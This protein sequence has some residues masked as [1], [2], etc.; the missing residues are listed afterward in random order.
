MLKN[1]DMTG[2]TLS[3]LSKLD[4]LSLR[5]CRGLDLNDNMIEGLSLTSLTITPK[6]KL[7]VSLNSSITDIIKNQTNLTNLS[8]GCFQINKTKPC[9]FLLSLTHLATLSMSNVSTIGYKYI[10]E[11]TSLTE[12]SLFSYDQ[13][14]SD[15]T[16]DILMHL[17]N[18]KCLK[19]DQDNIIVMKLS[20]LKSLTDLNVHSYTSTHNQHLSNLTNIIRLSLDGQSYNNRRNRPLNNR[21]NVD[22]STTLNTL[23][24]LTRLSLSSVSIEDSSMCNLTNLKILSLFNVRSITEQGIQPLT[25]LYDLFIISAPIISD[26]CLIQLT[27]LCNL[28]LYYK[29]LD[30]NNQEKMLIPISWDGFS[31]LKKLVNLALSS[32]LLAQLKEQNPDFEKLLYSKINVVRLTVRT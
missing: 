32:K 8:L 10:K 18:L 14:Q 26:Q 9:D 13:T 1:V 21:P 3:T 11:L 27:N 17:P 12:L 7:R 19:S 4:K 28:T 31:T 23:V 25:K 2:I 24:N 6:I 16:L 20:K 22:I 15:L 30:D 5:L 29:C